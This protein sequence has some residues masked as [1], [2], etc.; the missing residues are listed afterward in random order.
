M[1]MARLTQGILFTLSVSYPFAFVAMVPFSSYWWMLLFFVPLGALGGA[2][3][4]YALNELVGYVG[5]HYLVF[6][7]KAGIVFQK[8]GSIRNQRFTI[9]LKEVDCLEYRSRKGQLYCVGFGEW[10]YCSEKDA[11]RV[12]EL[13]HVILKKRERRPRA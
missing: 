9:P 3:G 6:P 13:F 12:K 11:A 10:I 1:V 8:T 4:L 7:K 2:I 5:G